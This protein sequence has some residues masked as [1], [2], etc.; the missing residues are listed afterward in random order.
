MK[1]N[2]PTP[3]YKSRPTPYADTV[4]TEVSELCTKHHHIGKKYGDEGEQTFFEY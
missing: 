1:E 3:Y 4:S 2:N